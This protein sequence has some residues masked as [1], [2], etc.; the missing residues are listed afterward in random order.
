MDSKSDSTDQPS[1]NESLPRKEQAA[2]PITEL[3]IENSPRINDIQETSDEGNLETQLIADTTQP[4]VMEVHHHT[5]TARKKWHHYFFEFFMLFLAVFCGFFAEYKLEH[6]VEKDKEKQYIASLIR[7]LKV[8]SSLI[9]QVIIRNQERLKNYDSIL[10]MLKNFDKLKSYN[11]LYPN[12]IETTYLDM[13]SATDRTIQQLKN[14]GGLR[15]ISN[16]EVSD[17]ITIYY[18]MAKAVVDQGN[19]WLRY[20]DEYHK[21]AFYLFDYSQIDSFYYNPKYIFKSNVHL[22]LI[23]N[24]R[25]LVKR[26]YNKL[27]VVRFVTV[28]YLEVIQELKQKGKNCLV[29]LKKEYNVD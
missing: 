23:T 11:N 24:N 4:E 16:F 17:S 8:D 1:N 15:L 18:E 21:D 3:A 5:H 10:Y 13:F 19:I 12:F 29:F 7:D 2:N 25:N 14:S 28:S 27:F 22:T 6:V 20:F 26:V 9:N